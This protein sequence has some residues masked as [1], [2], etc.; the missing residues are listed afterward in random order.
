MINLFQTARRAVWKQIFII[1]SSS[2]KRGGTFSPR[3]FNHPL[4]TSLDQIRNILATD[5]GTAA[6]TKAA[7]IL[8]NGCQVRPNSNS[9][10]NCTLLF[11]LNKKKFQWCNKFFFHFLDDW[12]ILGKKFPLFLIMLNNEYFFKLNMW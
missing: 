12:M 7:L 1:L 11:C 9:D 4:H 8:F 3:S 5:C 10:R 2:K 6:P